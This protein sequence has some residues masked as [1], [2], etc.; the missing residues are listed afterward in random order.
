MLSTLSNNTIHKS[1]SDKDLPCYLFWRTIRNVISRTVTM[2][3]WTC[4]VILCATAVLADDE[5]L[6]VNT[7]QGPIRGRKHSSGQLYEFFNIPYATGPTGHLK[8]K[9]VLIHYFY[10]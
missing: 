6:D 4:V 7:T 8:F 1:N 2:K 9:V 10:Y 5:W 3:W